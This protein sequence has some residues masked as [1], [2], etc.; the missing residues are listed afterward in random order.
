LKKF[1]IIKYVFG[2]LQVNTYLIG[3]PE[4]G[5]CFCIDPG[6]EENLI[7][8]DL[9]KRNWKLKGILITHG[10]FDHVAGVGNLKEKIDV[11]VYIHKRDLEIYKRAPDS[12]MRYLGVRIENLPEI[13]FYLE[14]NQELCLG[15]KKIFVLHTP[16]HTPG[17][18]CFYTGGCIFT[19]DL[20]FKGT[21]GRA[22]FPGGSFKQLMKSIFEKILPL[23]PETEILPGHGENTNLKN[24]IENNPYINTLLNNKF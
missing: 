15:N 12:M 11:P 6:G 24:E 7:L 8:E 4:S 22:D 3:D 16:G 2:P 23:P 9:N 14:D 5:E 18:V 19:G 21:V 13:D 10:H 17:S 1:K 20:I